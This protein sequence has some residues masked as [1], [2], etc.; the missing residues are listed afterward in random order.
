MHEAGWAKLGTPAQYFRIEIPT[1][2]LEDA[3]P[4]LL[5]AGLSGWNC[6][7]PHK[8][9]MF[10]LTQ[11]HDST[12][13][14]AKSVNT[15]QIVDGKIHGWSTDAG[16]WSRAMNEAWPCSVPPGR[17]LILG[18]GGVGQSIARHLAQTGCHSLTLVNRDSKRAQTLLRELTPLVAGR[19]PLRQ[20]E[21]D[22]VSLPK[23]LS[24]TDL[25]IHGTTLGMKSDDSLPISKD[26]ITPPLRIYDTLY[27]KDFTPLVQVARERG[28]LAE[29]G[30]TMLLHQGALS[31]EIW[32]K[33]PAP[34]E[35]MRTALN[36]ATG[37]NL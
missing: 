15:V 25:L 20:V 32:S 1:G 18:C 12:A 28:C 27:K 37:R 34:L 33:K 3:I 35:S 23:A 7:L 6:T 5:Q 21:W 22:P 30:L 14:E 31:F 36:L 9:E 10:R 13:L 4:S 19:F 29:D 2:Q 26:W 8:I 16:G 11:V 17:T 24:E